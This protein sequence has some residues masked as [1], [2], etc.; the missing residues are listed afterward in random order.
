[1][2]GKTLALYW[3]ISTIR[4]FDCNKWGE[5]ISETMIISLQLAL[6]I[7][8]VGTDEIFILAQCIR[9][10]ITKSKD[11]SIRTTVNQH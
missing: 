5:F 7:T 8:L 1:M 6:I 3:L 4:S 2:N 9:T 10:S 11:I